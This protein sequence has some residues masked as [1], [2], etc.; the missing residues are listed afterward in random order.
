MKKLFLVLFFW[1][2]FFP[3]F[4]Q[5]VL[6][7]ADEELYREIFKTQQKE[8]WKTADKYIAQVKDKSLMG[9]VLAQRYF[10]KNW[11]TKAK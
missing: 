4:S 2:V 1:L 5:D 3:A 9:H 11:T 10:S 8:D 7:S 6:S